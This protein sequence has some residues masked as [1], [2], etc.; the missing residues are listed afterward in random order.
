MRVDF[1]ED[2]GDDDDSINWL[3]VILSAAKKRKEK[4]SKYYLKIDEERGFI[5]NYI[6][7]LDS[8]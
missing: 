7:I 2:L 1:S 8:S 4:L 5:F 6:T 3:V